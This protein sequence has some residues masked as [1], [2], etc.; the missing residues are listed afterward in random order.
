MDVGELIARHMQMVAKKSKF[1]YPSE[2]LCKYEHHITDKGKLD[3]L[4]YGLRKKANRFKKRSVRYPTANITG[5][6]L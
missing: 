4:Q 6:K 5:I 3:N 2:F 1:S